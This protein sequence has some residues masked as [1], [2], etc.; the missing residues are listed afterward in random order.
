MIQ[1]FEVLVGGTSIR[2]PAHLRR[3]TRERLLEAAELV[4]A[5]QGYRAATIR[6][7]CRRAGSN[8]SAVNYYFGDKQRLYSAAL[9]H[10]YRCCL[11]AHPPT[12][13]LTAEAPAE[14]KLLAFVRALL[15]RLC[16]QGHPALFGRLMAR[17]MAEPTQALDALIDQFIRPQ[18]KLILAI[19]RE[20]LGREATE[21]EVR[22]CA[23]SV[24][25]QCLHY[26]QASAVTAR[27][28]PLSQ[29]TGEAIEVVARHITRF[30]L[31]AMRHWAEHACS[32]DA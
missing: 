26:M 28:E 23:F 4:F 6:E 16:G 12:G 1:L 15:G 13:L 21:Q 22:F 18:Y 14:K 24:V 9:E 3:D 27:L 11:E 25:G 17:E 29:T 19:N 32:E 7:I 31:A 8:I 5:Q 20:L 10:S 2:A 30:S